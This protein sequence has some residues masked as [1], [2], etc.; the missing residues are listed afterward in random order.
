[1]TLKLESKDLYEKMLSG[2]PVHPADMTSKHERELRARG[3]VFEKVEGYF[4]MDGKAI[5]FNKVHQKVWL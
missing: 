4:R 2:L 3:V 5:R 1:M